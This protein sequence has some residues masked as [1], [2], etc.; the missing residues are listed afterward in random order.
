M[1]AV[2]LMILLTLADNILFIVIS[3][4]DSG[5]RVKDI[6]SQ[7]GPIWQTIVAIFRVIIIVSWIGCRYLLIYEYRKGL[8]ETWKALKSFWTLHFI[9]LLA[10]TVAG[11]VMDKMIL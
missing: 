6:E 4:N 2:N 11:A 8:S 3:I 5:K 9:L 1:C 10:D 7:L